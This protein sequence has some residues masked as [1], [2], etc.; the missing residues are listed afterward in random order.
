[1]PQTYTYTARNA[2]DPEKVVT[3]TLYHDSLSVSPGASLEQIEAAVSTLT[4]GEAEVSDADL[5]L[6][7]LA[8]SLV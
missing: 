7:P 6:K 1:M 2:L 4:E 3:F 5:W 8:I